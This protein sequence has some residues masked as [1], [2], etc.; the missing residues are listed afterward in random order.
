TKQVNTE[1]LV[2]NGG[3]VG[4]GGIYTQDESTSVNKIPWLGDLPIVGFFFR[5][6]RRFNDR[7][8]LL[9]FVTPRIIKDNLT[10]R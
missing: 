8:E 3:T 7:R 9:V 10:L 2:E 5:N 6:E 1:V 4:I